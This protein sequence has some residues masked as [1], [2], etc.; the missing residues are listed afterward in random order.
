MT[1]K[2]VYDVLFIIDSVF[3]L[4]FIF[5]DKLLS[6]N[7]SRVFNSNL[8]AYFLLNLFSLTYGINLYLVCVR[9]NLHRIKY[10]AL[11]SPV[12]ASIIRYNP[13]YPNA[14]SSN[15]HLLCAYISC[16]LITLIE[17]IILFRYNLELKMRRILINVY[18]IIFVFSLY[19]YIDQLFVSLLNEIIYL[20]AILIINL[21]IMHYEVKKN[22]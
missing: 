9:R 19:L 12:I 5:S 8:K 17:M 2:R 16:I 21:V 15:M 18:I 20:E 22:E 6:S 1:R 13:A 4:S 14:L 11:L 3:L 10:L 7:L